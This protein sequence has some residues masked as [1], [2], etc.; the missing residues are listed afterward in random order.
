MYVHLFFLFVLLFR[1]CDVYTA[2]WFWLG[3][4]KRAWY[5]I[6]LSCLIIYHLHHLL[7]LL[8][9]GIYN[10]YYLLSHDISTTV[11][12][13]SSG[14]TRMIYIFFFFSL[15]LPMPACHVKSVLR[16]LRPLSV[17]LVESRISWLFVST[18]CFDRRANSGWGR[19]RGWI[20]LIITRISV[21]SRT[22]IRR[23]ARSLIYSL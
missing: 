6:L 5:Y 14:F 4:E 17:R 19:E 9:G 18:R 7:L 3:L 8:Y 23:V 12:T 11:H 20:L 22:S 1:S 10:H 15:S 16:A 21:V 13:H 2:H